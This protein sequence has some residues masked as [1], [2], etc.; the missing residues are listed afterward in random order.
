MQ[1]IGSPRVTA[2]VPYALD[3]SRPAG[4]T[5]RGLFVS[6]NTP[7]CVATPTFGAVEAEFD[8]VL[9]NVPWEP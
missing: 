6:N 2:S 1:K 5:Y 7:N 8:R 3:D 9:V 4:S